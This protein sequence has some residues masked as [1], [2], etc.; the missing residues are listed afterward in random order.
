[1]EK[2]VKEQALS[3]YSTAYLKEQENYKKTK[4]GDKRFGVANV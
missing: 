3:C 2:K 1:L 4:K